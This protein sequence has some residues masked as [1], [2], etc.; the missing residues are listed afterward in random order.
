MAAVAT[1]GVR[2]MKRAAQFYEGT[3]GLQ[4]IHS[5]GEMAAEYKTGSSSLFVYQS[6]F[7][8][9]NKATAV[10]WDVG[11]DVERLVRDLKGKG[12]AFEHYELPDTKLDGDVHVSGDRRL[13][14]LKD[15]DGNILALAGH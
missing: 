6:Q 5:M 3:L 8:G 15:P 1:V 12:V 9:T 7:A 2:D 4:R 11:K 14:W 13:A 10:T